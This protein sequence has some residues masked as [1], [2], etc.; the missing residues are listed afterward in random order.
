[1]NMHTL[2]QRHAAAF[3]VLWPKV[4]ALLDAPAAL[5]YKR[6]GQWVHAGSGSVAEMVTY[7]IGAP[8]F[9]GYDWRIVLLDGT[10]IREW[11]AQ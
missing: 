2:Y 9:G 5:E 7:I 4:C 8:E 11:G 10:V 3:G 6:R 1:M